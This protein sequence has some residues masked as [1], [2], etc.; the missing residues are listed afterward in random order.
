M[1]N[2]FK[3]PVPGVSACG[4]FVLA[5]V[6]TSHFGGS[7]ALA[8]KDDATPPQVLAPRAANAKKPNLILIVAD[9]LG[10]GDLSLTGS[11]QIATPNIDRL[12]QT[13]MFFPQGYVS[14]AVCSPS[15]AGFITGI[16]GVEFGYDNNLGG[17]QPGSDGRFLGLPVGQ[18]TIATLLKPAG[19][20]TGLVGKWHL[21][22]AEQFAPTKR[23]F[24]DFWGFRG[25]GHDYFKVL[26]NGKGYNAPI[27]CNTKTPQKITYI[28][29]DMGDENVDFIKRHKAQPFFL[30]ASFNAPHTP[31]EAPEADLKL[32]DFIPEKKRRTYAAMVHRLDVNV[33]RI[34]DE[35]KK[36]GLSENTL[37]VFYSDNG[38]PCDQNSSVNA[39]YRGQKGILL[40]GG[41]HVPFIMNWPGVIPA[42]KVFN[43]PVSSLD[44]APTFTAL[45]GAEAAKPARPFD[46]VDLMPYLRGEKT[47][48][49]DR[50]LKWRFTI[51]KAIRQGKWKLV[52]VPDRLPQLYDLTN[53]IAEQ[54]NVA[55]KKLS[56]NAVD[57]ENAGPVGSA[58]A[59][60]DVPGRCGLD[61]AASRFIRRRLSDHAARARWKNCVH[62]AAEARLEVNCAA[63]A[64]IKCPASTCRAFFFVRYLNF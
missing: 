15:R 28:T 36:Q 19:Y 56:A 38:G 41:V 3:R 17:I 63:I 1:N 51:S 4:A 55:A 12:A 40:E 35:V 44:V 31:M 32:F 59:V 47:G 10:Y 11:N 2:L 14:S 64:D 24:D 48:L 61:V 25:G 54:N 33:G 21:G 53:D 49:A 57:V 34:V 7:K 18:K 42:G 62:C 52:S 37:I 13:G 20:A 58:F 50:Q 46:G 5:V 39:P 22:D 23:G 60:S 9:D 45:A 43:D 6:A 30:F 29:D 8:Q 27:E 26:P 16:N